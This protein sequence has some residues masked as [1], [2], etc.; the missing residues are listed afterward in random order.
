MSLTSPPNSLVGLSPPCTVAANLL[1]HPDGWPRLSCPPCPPEEGLPAEGGLVLSSPKGGGPSPPLCLHPSLATV[2]LSSRTR[3]PHFANGGEE[4]ASSVRTSRAASPRENG[5]PRRAAQRPCRFQP[6]HPACNARKEN[7][8]DW[9]A[10]LC[11]VLCCSIFRLI[12]LLLDPT[13]TY[14]VIA[15]ELQPPR[16]GTKAIFKDFLLRLDR[17][18]ADSL[19]LTL[20]AVVF[21]VSRTHVWTQSPTAVE[22]PSQPAIFSL[23]FA[24]SVTDL[25]SLRPKAAAYLPLEPGCSNFGPTWILST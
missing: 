16:Y 1:R 4:S 12:R 6:L 3:S 5:G 17:H 24:S 10:R 19:P 20:T 21:F 18:P 2:A 25:Q 14:R 11:S 9:F 7:L 23:A 13:W 22:F 8:S 15:R